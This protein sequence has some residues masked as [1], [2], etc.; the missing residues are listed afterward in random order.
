MI[1][2]FVSLRQNLVLGLRH[3]SHDLHLSDL[4][5]LLLQ[6]LRK[7]LGPMADGVEDRIFLLIN[8]IH[9]LVVVGVLDC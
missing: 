7:Q 5:R 8:L 1:Q 2:G 4:L 3:A 6:S 9:A